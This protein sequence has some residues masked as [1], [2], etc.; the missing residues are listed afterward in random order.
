MLSVMPR[1]IVTILLSTTL[2]GCAPMVTFED[3]EPALD[4]WIGKPVPKSPHPLEWSFRKRAAN[5][6]TY[7]LVSLRTDECNYVLT[8]RSV[9]DIILGWRFVEAQRTKPCRFQHVRQLM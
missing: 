2:L 3:M 1:V 8:V 6:D 7:E 9:D 4:R 5:S